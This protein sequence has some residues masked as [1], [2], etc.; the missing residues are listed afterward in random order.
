MLIGI[1]ICLGLLP[2]NSFSFS[3]QSHLKLLLIYYFTMCTFIICSEYFFF[4][5]LIKPN[6]GL[7]CLFP[8]GF[9]LAKPKKEK[10]IIS[11][12]FAK[13]NMSSKIVGWLVGD[14]DGKVLELRIKSGINKK[15][16]GINPVSLVH[17]SSRIFQ[18]FP[19][20]SKIQELV[21]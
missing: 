9:V 20:F 18:E 21:L 12:R 15:K 3:H 19:G 17:M 2:Q 14:R 8:H 1:M 16:S 6:T 4:L 13:H 11:F 10:E 5:T 7:L